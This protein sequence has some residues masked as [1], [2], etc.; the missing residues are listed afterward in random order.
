MYELKKFG[1]VL[2]SKFVWTRP[3]SYEKRTYRAAVSQRLRNTDLSDRGL[4]SLPS[5]PT[6]PRL[7]VAYKLRLFFLHD[8]LSALLEM[9]K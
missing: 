8:S 6:V 3:L 9:C 7:R 5:S 1:K 2:K 4:N